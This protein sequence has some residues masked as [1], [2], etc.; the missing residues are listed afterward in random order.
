ML[1]LFPVE[2]VDAASVQ[3]GLQLGAELGLAPEPR[4]EHDLVEVDA[5]APPQ[6]AQGP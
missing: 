4:G 1:S 5:E 3:P 6:L 2:R